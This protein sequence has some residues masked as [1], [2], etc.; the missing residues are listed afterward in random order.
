MYN[1]EN[2]DGST[3]MAHGHTKG[4]VVMSEH[5]GF[6]LIHS[7][8]MYPPPTKDGAYSYPESGH[9]YGQSMLC[10]S[11]SPSQADNVGK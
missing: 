10:I 2:P 3:S 6:W 1:D 9:T 7:V 5:G 11:L 4:V 8:P